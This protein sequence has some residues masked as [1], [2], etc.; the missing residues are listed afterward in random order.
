[1]N[2]K[3]YFTLLVE[4]VGTPFLTMQEKQAIR[5]CADLMETIEKAI[6]DRRRDIFDAARIFV[7]DKVFIRSFKLHDS[8]QAEVCFEH[9]KKR[10]FDTRHI[11][12]LPYFLFKSYWE[13]ES[14]KI[15][16]LSSSIYR[17]YKVTYDFEATTF[18]E[19]E[20]YELKLRVEV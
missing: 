10:N 1:M 9:K 16:D 18:K 13:I 11:Y 17:L 5:Y 19:N 7:G 20:L 4:A 3:E 8:G 2:N 14:A 12:Y 15:D 6:K